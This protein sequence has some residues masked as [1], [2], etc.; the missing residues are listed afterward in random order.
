MTLETPASATKG[1]RS[2]KRR[3]RAIGKG[4]KTVMRR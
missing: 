3:R 2:L 1:T 4:A